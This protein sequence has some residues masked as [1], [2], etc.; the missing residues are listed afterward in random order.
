MPLCDGRIAWWDHEAWGGL[1]LAMS[2]QAAEK[3]KGMKGLDATQV[4]DR[5]ASLAL[6]ATAEQRC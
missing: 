4:V 5:V 3:R 2:A 6:L 1:R